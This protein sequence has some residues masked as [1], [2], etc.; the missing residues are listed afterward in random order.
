MKQNLM[1]QSF[2]EVRPM[3]SRFTFL[4]VLFFSLML[5]SPFAA[6]EH[7][8][9]MFTIQVVGEGEVAIA[10]DIAAISVGVVREGKTARAALTAN[11]T[12]MSKVLGAMKVE[13]IAD[14]DLQTSGFT[15]APR[16]FYPPRENNQQQKPPTIVGYTVSNNL[17]VR[18][19]NLEKV[20]EIMD[21]VVTLGVN[22]GGNIQF[23][24]D[25]PKQ[26]LRQ[27]RTAAMADAID[28]AKTLADAAGVDLGKIVEIS[29][30]SRSSRP[31]PMAKGRFAAE[32]M[33]ADSVPVASGENTYHV[34]VNV[35]WEIDQ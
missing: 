21:L 22:S 23:L 25:N 10:P 7:H 30:H 18:I 4:T 2:I 6:S 9:R 15:I 3:G 12:A 32:A 28:K 29:E 1:E 11:N 16:Y 14:K 8:E 20:G 31:T 34:T 5:M 17:S 24:N 35:N 19:R 13:G 26:V 27:A 33:M